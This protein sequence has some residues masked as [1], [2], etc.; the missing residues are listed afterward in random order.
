M[1]KQLQYF[2][3][4]RFNEVYIDRYREFLQGMNNI[5]E[6]FS[7]LNIGTIATQEEFRKLFNSPKAFLFKKISGDKLPKLNGV[8]L[9][10]EKVYEISVIP[11]GVAALVSK[12]ETYRNDPS[13]P[14]PLEI[15][16]FSKNQICYSQQYID[17]GRESC[18][19]FA[20]DETE[21]S[22]FNFAKSVRQAAID[23][24]GERCEHLGD[25]VN[26]FLDTNIP[27]NA[28]DKTPR[29]RWSNIKNYK[30]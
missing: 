24:F 20:E 15:I 18:T 10:F 17:K 21:L 29:I 2:D 11:E 7:R 23:A 12:I 6:D 14:N 3:E 8:E 16:E 9:D 5:L 26:E 19:I 27:W 4:H 22:Y 28:V 30:K 25:K 1:E 13:L